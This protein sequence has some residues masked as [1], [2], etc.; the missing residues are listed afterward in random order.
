MMKWT[1]EEC[2]HYE[3]LRGNIDWGKKKKTGWSS[4]TWFQEF[5]KHF[6]SLNLSK[7]TR[8]SASQMTLPSVTRRP[9]M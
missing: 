2:Q 4:I 5:Q 8:Y 1:T 7:Q 6:F 3:N 9:V